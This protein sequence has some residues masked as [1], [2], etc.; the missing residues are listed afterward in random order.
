MKTN[1]VGYRNAEN[2][3]TDVDTAQ[4]TTTR[5]TVIDFVISMYTHKI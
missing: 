2:A 1:S 4:K 5:S 3:T